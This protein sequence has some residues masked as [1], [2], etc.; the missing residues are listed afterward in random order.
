MRRFLFVTILT[1]FLSI[2][3]AVWAISITGKYQLDQIILT[4]LEN[5]ILDD[6]INGST[7][8]GEK[9]CRSYGGNG[10][11]GST[12]GEGICRAGNGTGCYGSSIGEGICRAGNGTGC[13][14]SSIGE[15]ICRAGNGTGCYGKSI[16]EALK[17]L[18]TQDHE[19]D[20]D[21]FYHSSGQLVWA[22][23][24]VQTGRF[25]E[26]ERCASKPQSDTRWPNK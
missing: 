1:L 19:W 26:L 8:L 5:G 25:S 10:C 6:R 23:R 16:N 7:D 15:G 22:C 14:G 3:Q 2:S 18:P 9:I 21:Q 20:W 12:V 17:S 24:G 13:Y 4:L 11:Y